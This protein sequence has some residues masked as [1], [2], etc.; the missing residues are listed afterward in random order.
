MCHYLNEVI[1]NY[2]NRFSSKYSSLNNSSRTSYRQ[3][4]YSDDLSCQMKASERLFLLSF[5]WKYC[6]LG[7]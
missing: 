1:K 2:Y 3:G 6:I 5:L 4:D 7:Y